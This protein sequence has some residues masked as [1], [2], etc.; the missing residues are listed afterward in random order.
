MFFPHAINVHAD[1]DGTATETHA[2]KLITGPACEAGVFAF[3]QYTG[4][5]SDTTV[6]MYVECSAN[7]SN[8]WVPLITIA[9]DADPKTGDAAVTDEPILPYIRVRT[10][11]AGT[12]PS[13][14]ITAVNLGAAA[15]LTASAVA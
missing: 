4:G 3:V 9:L 6:T 2:A 7:G 1:T 13:A 11:V 5:S 14:I 12:A 15:P 10:V 8:G